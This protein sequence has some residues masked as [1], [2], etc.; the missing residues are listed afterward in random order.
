MT[1][2][3]SLFLLFIVTLLLSGCWSKRELNELAIVV[4]LGVDKVDDEY[5]ISVQVVD[6]SEIST[7][8]PSSGRSPVVTYHAKGETAFEAIRKMTTLT[9]RKAYFSHLQVVVLGEELAADGINDTLDFIARDHEFRNDF[10]VIVSS[11]STAKEVLN[12]LTP[13]EK[14]PANKMLNSIK[15]SQK[16]WG[17][18]LSVSI[19]ELVNTLNSNKK[20]AVLTAIE[21][22]GDK[23]LG[24]DQTNVERIKTPVV[25]KF[26]GLAVF[27]EDKLQGIL[28]EEE[29]RSFNF[30]NGKIES[31]VEII[32]CP[33]QGQ[34]TTEITQSTTKVKG[35]FK[36]DT[37]QMNVQI[38]VEQNVGEVECDINLTENKTIAYINKKTAELIEERIKQTLMTIQKNYQL[39]ILGF[40]EVLYR[41]DA[42]KWKGI[43]GEWSTIFPELAVNVEVRVT[44]QGLGTMQN[45]L[46][47]RAKE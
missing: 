13:I 22:D 47:H 5:E 46:L 8:Q 15:V 36:N 30:L 31:T 23:K 37:P 45:S 21:L 38:D 41:K 2:T 35:Q 33:E 19:D 1:K 7:K 11:K 32:A 27:K 34:L 28:T 24:I 26:V 40:G 10:D 17:S 43:Q 16:A 14:V 44:T 3:K 20:S 4:A 9:P 12:V 18:T 39:D 42:K 29:S 25:L 6:P